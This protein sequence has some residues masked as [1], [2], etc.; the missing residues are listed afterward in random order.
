MGVLGLRTTAE[1]V[2]ALL[3]LVF[4]GSNSS[5]VE[6]IV[7]HVGKTGSRFRYLVELVDE[8]K[9]PNKGFR[10]RP[11]LAIGN[12]LKLDDALRAC[13]ADAVGGAERTRVLP[14]GK[15]AARA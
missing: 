10:A 14:T 12:G 6:L 4:E 3:D 1:L 13:H 15:L 8:T 11:L 2:R 9:D 7:K 5:D